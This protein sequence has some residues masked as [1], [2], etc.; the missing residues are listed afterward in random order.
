M[1]FR[2]GGKKSGNPSTPPSAE[3]KPPSEADS[4]IASSLVGAEKCGYTPKK[5]PMEYLAGGFVGVL[6]VNEQNALNKAR[7]CR[8]DKQISGGILFAIYTAS[9]YFNRS[10]IVLGLCV[11]IALW[12]QYQWKWGHDRYLGEAIHWHE[13]AHDAQASFDALF[14]QHP[15]MRHWDPNRSDSVS[16]R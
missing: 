10:P 13:R 15:T 11:A 6:L 2:F 7:K 5:I 4:Q 14:T 1:H 3:E 9:F 12:M 16:S 8:R